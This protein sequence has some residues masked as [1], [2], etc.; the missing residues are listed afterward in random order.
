[1]HVAVY[2]INGA[3]AGAASGAGTVDVPVRGGEGLYIVKVNTG[4]VSV[5]RKVMMR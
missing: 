5:V 2:S 3:L 1:M 4:D